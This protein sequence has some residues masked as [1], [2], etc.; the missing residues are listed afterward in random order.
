MGWWQHLLATE[1]GEL[2]ILPPPLHFHFSAPPEHS[3]CSEGRQSSPGV[4]PE[5]SPN[6]AA[7]CGPWPQCRLIKALVI[8]GT[9]GR[10]DLACTPLLCP[11]PTRSE[12]LPLGGPEKH[13]GT[14]RCIVHASENWLHPF[15]LQVRAW[16]L[17]GESGRPRQGGV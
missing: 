10:G 14:C 2:P 13:V 7:L 3:S 12:D 9:A 8:L 15:R 6:S 1:L 4:Y 5:Q 17:V 11:S 16:L